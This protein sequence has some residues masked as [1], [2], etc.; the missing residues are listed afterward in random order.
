MLASGTDC[1]PLLMQLLISILLISGVF[2][3]TIVGCASYQN[4]ELNPA[5]SMIQLENRSLSNPELLSFIE[6]AT[7]SASVTP[8]KTWNIDRLT[9]VA[10]YY[11]PDLALAR[12]Q[13]QSANSAITTAGQRPNPSIT[14]SPTWI[15]NLATA[16]IPWIAASSISI[17]I[18][19]AGKRDFRIGKAEHMADAARLRIADAAWLVRGRL[20]SALL[21]AYTAKEAER[22][23]HQ[24]Y[25]IQQTINQRLEQQ[26][27]IGEIG[28]LEVTRSH[29]A[30]NQLKLN[31][32]AARKR[33]AESAVLLASAVGVPVEGL[34][35]IDLDFSDLSKPPVL[36]TIPVSSLKEH[37][38]LTRPDV[39]AA[40]ADYEAAQSALQ[41]EIANQYPN[42]Q[43]NPG[44]AWEMGEHRWTLGA[45][46]QLPILHQNQ[47]PIAEAEAK[48]RE[49]AVRFESLQMRIVSDI[50]RAHSGV[51]AVLAKWSDAETQIQL[52]QK[53][54]SSVQAQYQVGEIDHL[55]LL[56]A[57][58]E[59]AIAE[60]T[61][62]D[63][64][65][66]TQQALNG[67][68]DT[69]RQPLASTLTDTLIADSANR[70]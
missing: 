2:I 62:L 34:T 49:L 42:I 7:G 10:I 27:A 51:T 39:L 47:G 31:E 67:L 48:R 69:L 66:E 58:L 53:N 28:P 52:Q 12:A 16:A 65:V 1:Y 41:L 22:L 56:G 24:Q 17:P 45:T 55:S 64:L 11:H 21:E 18:E 50:D 32:N 30:V 25:A 35:G 38:L 57:E 23:S 9:L 40:L 13:A 61:K 44:Y 36:Q 26:L 8:P 60:R 63:V 33:V 20:R 68:E 43:A 37:A 3:L 54:L 5:E 4:R 19:T 15:R 46:M 70:K 59:K 14:I 6:T 29:L